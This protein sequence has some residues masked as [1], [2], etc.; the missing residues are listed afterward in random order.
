MR[1]HPLQR[2]RNRCAAGGRN[3]CSKYVAFRITCLQK[4]HMPHNLT[5]YTPCQFPACATRRAGVTAQVYAPSIPT[6]TRLP[7]T[8][9]VVPDAQV[10]PRPPMPITLAHLESA[11]LIKMCNMRAFI[12][13]YSK[14]FIR[15]IGVT[16]KLHAHACEP[17]DL[18]HHLSRYQGMNAPSRKPPRTTLYV[19]PT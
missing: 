10:R 13:F 15:A 14:Y 5:C 7:S 1:V 9:C 16:F 17:M 3:F 12:R 19:W 2:G 11:M 8:W 6:T 4:Y 18:V